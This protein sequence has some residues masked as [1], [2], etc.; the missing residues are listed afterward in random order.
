MN[1]ELPLIQASEVGSYVYCNRQWWLERVEGIEVTNPK[2]V[3][4]IEKGIIYHENH[5]KTVKTIESQQTIVIILLL[6]VAAGAAGWL[7]AWLMA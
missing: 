3:E 4:A 7:F 2:T 5:A 6:L 1:D